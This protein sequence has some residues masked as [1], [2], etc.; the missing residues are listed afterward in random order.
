MPKFLYLLRHSQSAEK[1]VGQSD[2]ERELTPN[3]IK[4]SMLIGTFLHRQGVAFDVIFSSSANRAT[5]TTQLV[6]DSMRADAEKI[7]IE[8]GLYDASI[9]TFYEFI[10]QLDDSYNNVMCVGH[11]P[12]ISWLSEFLTNAHL[13]EMVPGGL[14]IIK[15]N[16]LSWKEVSKGCGEFINYIYP[17]MLQ[18]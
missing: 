14:A 1:Q 6:S 4:E 17:A 12:T 11:N 5:S 7:F 16:I 18:S 3:G 13:A 2:K 10:T 15:F 9:R 8:D